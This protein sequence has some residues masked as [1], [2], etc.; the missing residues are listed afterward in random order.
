MDFVFNRRIGGAIVTCNGSE[1]G[2]KWEVRMG[3]E[4]SGIA[5][6]SSKLAAKGIDGVD[7]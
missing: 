5:G 7:S 1:V 3:V 2:V 4:I 6:R